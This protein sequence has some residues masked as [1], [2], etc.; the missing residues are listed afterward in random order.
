MKNTVC[1]VT[2]GS[3]HYFSLPVGNSVVNFV[4]YDFTCFEDQCKD[5]ATE[6]RTRGSFS[7]R[8]AEGL[9]SMLIKCYPYCEALSLADFEPVVSDYIINH[10][11]KT[12]N[13]GLESL[14]VE[15][16]P[17]KSSFEEMAFSRI[18]E[19]KSGIAINQWINLMRMRDYACRKLEFIFDGEPVSE[20]EYRTRKDYFDLG[21]RVCAHEMGLSYSDL[22]VIK[23]Y[24]SS[25]M[26][27][28]PFILGRPAREVLKTVDSLLPPAFGPELL[29]KMRNNTSVADQL[30]GLVFPVIRSLK[31]PSPM[32]MRT[33]MESFSQAPEEVYLA[34]SF[35]AMLDLEF[36]LM[37][38]NHVFY[39]KSVQTG[40]YERIVPGE[41]AKEPEKETPPSETAAPKELSGENTKSAVILEE[42]MQPPEKPESEPAK[43]AGRLRKPSG[44]ASRRSPLNQNVNA[45]CQS[46][47]SALYFKVG[48]GLDEK[49]FKEWSQYLMNVRKNIIRDLATTEDLETFLDSSEQLYRN[50]LQE[51]Q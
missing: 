7:R 30:S 10:I 50:L 20:Q 26:P 4:H 17:L 29:R 48:K 46:L 31:R 33:V 43:K 15:C 25:L 21:F 24:N 2:A 45:R 16:F 8:R 14:W 39:K 40:K 11:C 37:I 35:K 23:R 5:M 42:M 18:S 3:N 44:G 34:E 13:I 6:C 22:P 36:D 47:Y 1:F 12:E 9:K 38:E 41:K 51:K 19:Y 32:E 27:N 49:E 28:A